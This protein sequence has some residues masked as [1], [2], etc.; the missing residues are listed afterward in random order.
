MATA[1]DVAKLAGVSQSTVSYVMSGARSISP[2]TRARVE[3]AMRELAYHPNAGARALA[4]RR[5]NVIGLVARLPSN[6]DVAALLPFIDTISS[7]CRERDFDLVLITED[8]GPAGLE[9]LAGRSIVD[10]IVLM[11]IRRNDDRIATVR[12]LDV[13]CVLIGVP[14]DAEGIDCIDFD[15]E[16]AGRMAVEHLISTGHR[17]IVL[18]GEPP[19]VRAEDFGF[20]SK[21]YDGASIAALDNAVDFAIFT[22]DADGWAGFASFDAYARGLSEQRAGIIA[23]TPQAVDIVMQSL[24][25]ADLQLGVDVSLVGL[26]TDA[27]AQGFRTHVTNVSPEPRD[28]S[29]LAMTTLFRRLGGGDSDHATRL[30]APRLT[31]RYTTATF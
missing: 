2:E 1:S 29:R 26:C 31:R 20:I 22:P 25:S 28:V 8:E 16:S 7:F 23:R 9:R 17:K 3:Q 10:G 4:G 5:T 30:V 14:D 24:A 15:V 11:D 21:F 27:T 18:V 13:P 6:T 12:K 19:T